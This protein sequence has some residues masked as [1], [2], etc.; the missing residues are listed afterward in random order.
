[1]N[2]ERKNNCANAGYAFFEVYAYKDENNVLHGSNIED[3]AS[4]ND[5][6]ITQK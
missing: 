3:F 5:L 6:I 4:I 2:M 1:M